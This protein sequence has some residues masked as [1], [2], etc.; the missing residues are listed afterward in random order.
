MTEINVSDYKGVWVFAEQRQGKLMNVAIELLGEGRKIADGLK[1]DLTA[2]I[3]GNGVKN[4]ADELACY[5]ADKV[6]YAESPLLENYTTDGYAYTISDLIRERKPEVFLIGATNIGRD[7]GPRISANI[8]TGLTAD[9]TKLEVD[10]ENHRLLQTRPAFGGNLMAT[11]ICPNHRPQMS[12][13]RPGVMAKAKR[14]DSKKGQVEVVGTKV[15]EDQ[16]RAKVTDVKTGIKHVVQLE[17]AK[18]IVSGGRGL[19]NPEGFKLIKELAEKLGGE[20]GA[21]RATVDAG[22]IP[23]AHQV[24]Q[25][26]KTVHPELYIACGIS[27]A[28]QHLAG[29]S[30]SKTI[31][32]INKDKDAP[33]FGICDYGI[34]GDVYEIIP[35]IISAIDRVDDLAIV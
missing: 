16:I 24:G 1:T 15:T 2:V 25:T 28:I 32:A 5:G 10:E 11:I 22:W 12:T 8:H 14:D 4:L 35:E 21:S 29:M 13:V 31:V 3:L 27:G 9:C 26:G 18:I 19:G 23:Q 34:V 33:I 17:E 7:L 30:D 6:I 20:V